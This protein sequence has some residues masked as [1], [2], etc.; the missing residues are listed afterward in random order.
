MGLAYLIMLAIYVL[1]AKG[2]YSI[3]VKP[4]TKKWIKNSIIAFF[5]LLSTYDIIISNVLK[6][7]YCQFT[8]LEKINKMIDKPDGV[9]LVETEKKYDKEYGASTAETYIEFKKLKYMQIKYTDGLIRTYVSTGEY[10]INNH[11]KLNI[12]ENDM[13]SLKAQ[14]Y[15]IK[16]GS[17]VFPFFTNYFLRGFET[18]IIDNQTGE[19][20]A[21]TKTINHKKYNFDIFYGLKG[22]W[23][24][25]SADGALFEKIIYTKVIK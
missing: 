16:D 14:Y 15:I 18:K 12:E 7:Y 17:I 25:S 20:I 9:L 1:I 5:I 22:K 23:C 13:S 24:G 11:K 3:I 19:V 8:E 21:W 2:I 4:T 10:I 6:F